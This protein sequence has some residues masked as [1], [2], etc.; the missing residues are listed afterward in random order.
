[1]T[2]PPDWDSFFDGGSPRSRRDPMGEIESF[3]TGA[4][5]TVSTLELRSTLATIA[6]SQLERWRA[7]ATVLVEGDAWAKSILRNDYWT[8][9]GIPNPGTHFGQAS[10]WSAVAWSAAFIMACARKTQAALQLPNPVLGHPTLTENSRHAAYCWQAFRDRTAGTR[11]RFWA[12][13]PAEALVEAG[14]IVVKTREAVTVA[15]AWAATSAAAFTQLHVAR[16]H[17]RSHRRRQRAGHRR[18]R[19]QFSQPH[20]L[21]TDGHRTNQYCTRG[22]RRESGVCGPQAH[23]CGILGPVDGNDC[24]IR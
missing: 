7:G 23:G 10:W 2:S 6:E 17:R 9:I 8:G 5:V 3:A 4:A 20:I 14:D 13:Q 18:Q 11:G 21:R 15:Q 22:Q 19:R 1:M 16:R 12:F 24:V